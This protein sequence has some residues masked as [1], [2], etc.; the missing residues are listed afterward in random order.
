MSFKSIDMQV[1]VQRNLEASQMQHH[2][3]HKLVQDQADLAAMTDKSQARQRQRSAKVDET[4]ESKIR[5]QGQPGDGQS[6]SQSKRKPK[7]PK[8]TEKAAEKGSEHPFKG[9]HIDL[10]L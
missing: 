10:S 9:H 3:Q 2:L 7:M 5:D 6:Q 1:S 8:E 4:A